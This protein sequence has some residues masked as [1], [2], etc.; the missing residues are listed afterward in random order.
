MSSAN[1]DSFTS[2]FPDL[3]T[4]ISFSCLFTLA[5][6]SNTIVNTSGESQHPGLPPD[7]RGIAFNFSTLSIMLAMDLSHMTLIM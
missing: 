7:F 2:F 4:F 3:I 1:S 5:E 6:T